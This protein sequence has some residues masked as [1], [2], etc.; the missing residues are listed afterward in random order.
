MAIIKENNGDASADSESRYSIS[1]DD[2]FLGSLDPAGDNDWV[3]VELTADTVYDITLITARGRELLEI[4][5][6]EGST[7]DSGSY[8]SSADNTTLIFNPTVSGTYYIRVG[9]NS[10]NYSTNYE[11]SLTEN[12]TPLGTYDELA[13]FLTHGYW[14]GR[15]SKVFDVE[16]GGMLSAD[17]TSL[18]DE[19]QQLARRALEAWTNVSGIGF[20]YV[21]DD[22]HITFEDDGNRA[23]AYSIVRDGAVV[24]GIKIP[25][26]FGSLST[27][28]HEIGHAL[29]L[30]HPGPYSGSVTYG[31]NNIYLT[32][33]QQA[34]VMSYFPQSLNSYINA[35]SARPAT[36]MIADIIAIQNIYGV[37]VDINAGDTV[38]GFDSN[39]QGYLG[40]FFVLWAGSE[41]NPIAGLILGWSGSSPG[42]H[43]AFADLD[44][45]SDLDLIVG[46]SSGVIHFY[47][48]TGTATNP[49]FTARADDANPLDGIDVGFYS[50]TAFADLD[51]DGD[52]DLLIGIYNGRIYYFE[53]TGTPVNP[54]FTQRTGSTN[55]LDGISTNETSTPVFIDLDGDAD[56]DL[57]VGGSSGGVHYF[58]NI[59][60]ATNPAFT[61]RTDAVNPLND[62][63]VG[64]ISTPAFADLDGDGDP[65][66]VIGERDGIL[67]YFENTGSP[68]NPDFT[69]R[70]GPA[71]PLGGIDVGNYSI[72][73]F[74]DLDA[75]GDPDLVSGDTHSAIHY[76]EN[77]GARTDP[78]FDTRI[79]NRAVALTLYDNGGND[80]LDLRRDRSDQRV[81]MRSEGISDVYGLVG[82]LVIA[83]DTF[84][85]NFIAGYGNDVVIGNA[86]AN[87][88]VGGEGDDE[89]W[90]NEGDDVLEGGTGADRLD[91]GAG[92]DWVSY[93]GS[94]AGVS[95][96][97]Y[98][99][100]AQRGH[101]EGDTITGFENLRGS[102][103]PDILAGTGRANRLEGGAGVDRLYGGSGNDVLE[104]GAGADR[105]NG[106]AGLDWASYQGSDAGVTVNL[107]A[108]TVEGGHA[109]GDIFV[110]IENLIGSAYQDILIGNAETNRLDGG[111]GDDELRGNEDD[112]IL[113]GGPGGDRLYGGNG[114]DELWGN[115][116]DDILEGGDGGDEL[117]G[118]GGVDWLSYAGSDAGVSVRLYDGLAQR[119]HAEGDTVT[120]FE[121]LRGS[122]HPDI[123]AG[124]GR[125]NRLEGG[126]GA[127]RLYGGSGDDVLEGGTGADRLNGG[128]G[129]DWASYQGSDAGV[130]VNLEDGT[131]VG[132]HAQGDNFVDIEN[133]IGSA[134]QDI[135]IG[136]AET[137]RL[138]GGAGNDELR[139][140]EGDD[141][142]EGGA[143]ADWLEG[144]AGVDWLSYAGSDAGVSVR[145]YDGLAQRG[146][147]EGD[148]ISGFENLRGSAHPDIL[149]G[150][151]RANRLEGGAG[152]DRLYGGSGDDVLEGGTGA[153]R[154]NG[155]PGLDWA[156]YQGS[157]AGVTVN[158]EA[159]TVV[160]GHA[161]GDNFI[162]I[163][164]LIGS[165]YQDILIGDAETNRLDGG[166]GDDELR[167]NEGDDVLEGNSGQDQLYGGA[168]DDRIDGGDG[169]DEFWGDN[170]ADMLDGGTGVD[171]VYYQGSDTGV[172]VD[173]GEGTGEGG[174][175]AG[176]VITY[177][178]NITGS[179]YKDVLR[180]DDSA[181]RLEGG[182]GDDELHG[183]AGN[184]ELQGGIGD[185]SL[186]GGE[187]T[188]WLEGNEGDDELW[189]NGDADILEGG[190]GADRLDG[191]DGVDWVS[192]KGSDA[193][194][195][196]K[197]KDGTG[198]GGHADGDVMV[199][200]ENVIG[201]DYRDTLEGDDNDNRLEGGK[202]DDSLEGGAGADHLDG[203]AGRDSL[204]YRKSNTGVT[205]NL[206]NGTTGGGHAE[207]DVITGFDRVAGSSYGD[208][209]VGN[210]NYNF[211]DGGRGD[212]ELWGEDGNDTLLGNSGAD[213][214]F[215]GDGDDTL[216]GRNGGDLLDGG[217][218]VDSISYNGSNA[219]VMVNLK[220]GTVSG[221]SAEGDIIVNIENVQGS[222]FRD[223]LVG[224]DSANSLNG[225]GGDDELWGNGGDDELRGYVGDDELWGNGG[226]DVL[227]G[228]DGD[229]RLE[230][231]EGNDGLSG[232]K[233]A[234]QLFGG[235]DADRLFG[236]DGIDE[237]RGGDGDDSLFGQN[238]ADHLFGEGGNDWL[239]GDD[240]DD[241]LWGGDGDDRL[242]GGDGA[243]RLDGGDGSDWVYYRFSSTGVTV[244]LRDGTVTGNLTDGDE[245]VNIENV[246]G[247]DN[248]DVL[249]GNNGANQLY[250]LN[251]NDD[252]RGEG[253]N[254]V[255]FGDPGADRLDG[256]D[257]VDRVTYQWSRGGVTVNLEDGTGIRSDAQGDVITD[258]ENITGSRYSDILSGDADANRL[259]GSEGRDQLNGK[260]GNDVLVGGAGADRLDGG[261]GADI[262]LFDAGHGFDTILDF[263]DN[264]DRIDLTAFGLS[265]FDALDISSVTNGV[266]IDLSDY[267]GRTI[268]L[269]GFDIAN[270]DA[271]DF[272]F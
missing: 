170:G 207:G 53:N 57:V 181:N 197:L 209:L 32:D 188:D 268:L 270:L 91:G 229:D 192:Y 4:L 22:A 168:G 116:G 267:D 113:E 189:G 31:V 130:T 10:N 69:Q 186:I 26:A 194:V 135:L 127:D 251:G 16:P 219:G 87:R 238:D 252:L 96:R 257:G 35:S 64:S 27:Y 63:N 97:L 176:D 79:I 155:G 76:F 15:S 8:T 136:D 264:E 196:V 2:I 75:D 202:G 124:T 52:F 95:V 232:G 18:T 144:G 109:Q 146:H 201:S 163:E 221:G 23:Y 214:L 107:E 234:D 173:L 114:D 68:D 92:V 167:G 227:Y 86:A 88:L 141:V 36:P 223:M 6:S 121:N 254:D 48:N 206:K 125:A 94:D 59:G 259:E 222:R 208:M 65:D 162:D 84:I 165:A 43:P 253:G 204:S 129:L 78:E 55:P 110:D 178:E 112:D 74:A 150:T 106:G 185:D 100:L 5:D 152:A 216:Y 164:N 117:D 28:I 61:Q 171:W 250:G 34:T 262:F 120:G 180:G 263:S 54:D 183:N 175:A 131:V 244:D 66:L 240:G 213:R 122:A 67:N 231:G 230:G 118:G 51:D 166:A 272:L 195:T 132:G 203:G 193:G 184:D 119:G 93:Q 1:L 177:I 80:T 190:A 128:P 156:S 102:A 151:G 17:I 233:G 235:D 25:E 47:E 249:I 172:T 115:E 205:V 147:A 191:G 89:L 140:N 200:F 14:G 228:G 137:N 62:V 20:V 149:A 90:G 9:S 143:G 108:G 142:L 242:W 98:D 71:N 30:G 224:D 220:D 248:V 138:D 111:A 198:H 215:G 101:A 29:G 246:Q 174:Y 46:S 13:D 7:L 269:E 73:A 258:V 154:L 77:T 85:E 260:D 126:A 24:F 243:D 50:R 225:I 37:P 41:E 133:L 255:L 70:T 45:D 99:G 266:R 159:G 245:I 236:E 83:R 237:L 60:T 103:H 39:V 157:D 72:P 241:E 49:A 226:D 179:D 12:T 256:G 145:L 161:Q 239:N 247:S 56:F 42:D 104:G 44:G 187:G 211:L 160:G 3:R 134:Y 33:S 218:G 210:D 81:D 123:L 40:E 199:G 265:G 11:I 153:D 21:D 169:D 212:D 19:G 139:S 82:N 148:T 105:L 261:A 38:Y 271:S 182:A 158:L 217:A 58:E